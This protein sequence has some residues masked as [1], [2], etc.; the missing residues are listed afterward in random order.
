MLIKQKLFQVDWTRLLNATNCSEN[1]NLFSPKLNEI[2]DSVS[3]LVK[4]KISAKRKYREPWMTRGL[5]ISGHHKLCFYKETLKAT[6]TC[7][8]ITKYKEYQNMYNRTKQCLKLQYYQ[9]KAAEF[10]TD[11][12]KLWGILNQVIG[13]TRN[14][15]SIIPFI[16]VDGLKIHLPCRIANEFGKFHST[17]GE[18]MASKITQGQH[19]IDFY[20]SKMPRNIT[21]LVMRSTNVTEIEHI[22]HK[23]PKKTSCGHDTTSNTLLKQMSPSISFALNKIFNQSIAQGIS[24]D[25]MKLAEMIPLYKGNNQDQTINYQPISLLITISKVLEKLIYA[26]VYQYIEKNKILFNSQYSF[27]NK[28]SCEQALIELTGEILQ[29]KEWKFKSAAL[30]L[31]LSKA[32]DTLD[33]EILLSKLE[34]YGIW[35]VCNNWFLS[36]LSGRSLKA[37]VRTSEHAV[38]TSDKFTINYGA[39]QGSCLGPLLFI[40]FTNDIQAL[41]L[42]SSII[43]FADDTTLLSSTQNDQ[44]LRFHLEHNMLILMD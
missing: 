10:I 34:R 1:F 43:L 3:P 25:A 29:A 37:N 38:T 19:N 35:G 4:V 14:K 6:A 9:N 33:H 23:L 12:K 28:H 8:D 44:L 36:Y 24:P 21:S 2:M 31:D 16:T 39:A 41:P 26:Q 13:K 7:K 22:I 5:E 32:F 40:L 11:S 27:R 18:S 20:L 15:G 17:I 42:F 30:F